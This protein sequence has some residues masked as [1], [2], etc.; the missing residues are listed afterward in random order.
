MKVTE[1]IQ[2]D[3]K[4]SIFIFWRCQV[5]NT[6]YKFEYRVYGLKSSDLL[7][8]NTDYIF[9]M[10]KFWWEVPPFLYIQVFLPQMH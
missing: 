6:C 9:I 5:K 1:N 8:R 4:Y 3:V 10:L 7:F 2:T